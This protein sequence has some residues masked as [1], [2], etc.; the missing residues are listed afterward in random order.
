MRWVMLALSISFALALSGPA[1]AQG[2]NDWVIIEEG[3]PPAPVAPVPAQPAPSSAALFV[4]IE[5]APPGVTQATIFVDDVPVGPAPWQGV[6]APGAH[7]VKAEAAGWASKSYRT[8]AIPGQTVNVSVELLRN[9]EYDIGKWYIGLAYSF[10]V[11]SSYSSGERYRLNCPGIGPG[12]LVG[13]KLPLEGRWLDLGLVVGPWTDRWINYNPSTWAAMSR[14]DQLDQKERVGQGMPLSLALRYVS[15]IVKPFLYWSA[16]FEAGIL[17]YK[18]YR[19]NKA[20]EEAEEEEYGYY[21]ALA[22]DGARAIFMMTLRGGLAFLPVDWFEI[23]VDPI[24][25]GFH[26]VKPFG[27]VWTP[28]FAL[29]LRL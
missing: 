14:A 21:D 20:P 13:M 22:D 8:T 18:H 16:S 5:K 29:V 15:A 10:G 1:L 19:F 27:I 7:R 4:T 25:M 6:V 9:G 26:C 2:S 17:I 12:L 3:T 23:R 24:G 11:G 28:S